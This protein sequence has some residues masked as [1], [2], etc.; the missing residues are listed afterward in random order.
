MDGEFLARAVHR[1]LIGIREKTSPFGYKVDV[2]REVISGFI[3]EWFEK[4][5][6]TDDWYGRR[7]RGHKAA[8]FLAPKLYSTPF[9]VR[10]KFGFEDDQIHYVAEQ[11]A[12]KM[13]WEDNILHGDHFITERK[14][15]SRR[16]LIN[17]ERHTYRSMIDIHDEGYAIMIDRIAGVIDHFQDLI[18]GAESEEAVTKNLTGGDVLKAFLATNEIPPNPYFE[19]EFGL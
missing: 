8:F 2:T 9:K 1:C 3:Q 14:P 16:D 11:Q 7:Q 4:E 19:A 12:W 10:H 15:K 6:R 13:D 18:W 5:P 17:P